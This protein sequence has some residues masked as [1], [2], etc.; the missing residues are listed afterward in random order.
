MVMEEAAAVTAAKL[1]PTPE[2]LR[3][4][5]G[6][7]LLGVANNFMGVELL[8]GFAIPGLATALFVT[9]RTAVGF[10]TYKTNSHSLVRLPFMQ[11]G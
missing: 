10:T 8:T 11:T 4:D 3:P 6:L 7:L 9:G 5:D 1:P 2:W